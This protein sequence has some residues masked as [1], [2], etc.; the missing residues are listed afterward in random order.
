[1][2]KS[3]HFLIPTQMEA[4]FDAF[5]MNVASQCASIASNE[6]HGID[7]INA[8]DIMHEAYFGFLRRK[9]DFFTSS[10]EEERNR[11]K[12]SVLKALEKQREEVE[13]SKTTLEREKEETQKRQHKELLKKKERE[14][15]ARGKIVEEEK[16]RK[17]RVREALMAQKMED[18]K[19]KIVE[20]DEDGN[21][22][23]NDEEEDKDEQ[24][25]VARENTEKVEKEEEDP[26]ALQPGTVHPSPLNGGEA[27]HYVWSQTLQE[28]DVRLPVPVGTRA[29]DIVCEFT[30]TTFK[31][32]LKSERAL[33]I[34]E[35][36][37]LCESI[38]PDDSFWTLEDNREVRLTL[39]KSNQMSWWENVI[40]GDPR[41]DTKKVVP[42]N[43]NLADLD[44]ETRSTVEKMMYDQRQKAAGKPTSDQE[45]KM[46][47]MKKFMESHPEMDFSN[48]KFD[49]GVLPAGAFNGQ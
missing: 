8:I 35:K 46:G 28:V 45:S 16:K 42:E 31:F 32:G 23:I 48:C 5:F 22:V 41:I 17:E 3:H 34:P 40:K 7:G 18:A 29:K 9:T 1:M 20:L 49:D 47:L 11:G 14:D 39:T 30:A 13:K 15:E 36:S 43:S 26:H 4:Q 38:K 24:Q 10:I 33:R 21:E 19:K 44:G 37:K 2:S 27:E 25:K 6:H 12:T